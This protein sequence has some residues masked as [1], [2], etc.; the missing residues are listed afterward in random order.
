MEKK[1]A[2]LE[3]IK[4]RKAFFHQLSL[5]DMP[6]GMR[7]AGAPEEEIARWV[8]DRKEDEKKFMEEKDAQWQ[9]IQAIMFGLD[10]GILVV[11]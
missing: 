8:K 2:T 6:E 7:I 1:Y 11:K 4:E 5:E 3:K 9:E 10:S